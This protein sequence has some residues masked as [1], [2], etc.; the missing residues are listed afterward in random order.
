MLLISRPPSEINDCLQQACVI[1]AVC[2][3]CLNNMVPSAS[4]FPQYAESVSQMQPVHTA[5]TMWCHQLQLFSSMQ[6]QC[7]CTI[8][9]FSGCSLKCFLTRQFTCHLLADGM[10]SCWLTAAASAQI[11]SAESLFTQEYPIF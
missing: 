6:Y 2:A 3:Q 7:V 1:N 9:V 4:A 10:N 5:C 8:F 11:C